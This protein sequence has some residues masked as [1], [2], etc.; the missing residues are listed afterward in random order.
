MR[1]ILA[2]LRS[3][4]V[5][6]GR[7]TAPRIVIGGEDPIATAFGQDA[8]IVFYVSDTQAYIL[9]TDDAGGFGQLFLTY[10]PTL[11]TSLGL[12]TATVD[13]AT[14]VM[15]RADLF[16]SPCD[17]TTLG[18]SS[19]RVWIGDGPGLDTQRI[20]LNADEIR[21]GSAGYPEL[22]MD[23]RTLGFEVAIVNQTPPPATTTAL[24]AYANI[25]GATTAT[26]EKR[27]DNTAVELYMG[28]GMFSTAGGTVGQ[29]GLNISGGF[30]D[31]TIGQVLLSSPSVENC[32]SAVVRVP[33]LSGGGLPAG[34][35]TLTPRWR[36]TAGAGTL[37]LTA[38]SGTLSYYAREIIEP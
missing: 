19:S 17:L 14:E 15:T 24:A 37:T 25:A 20:D 11:G 9:S 26:F 2:G 30:G 22:K 29:Y 18:I 27:Y 6:W 34:T 10:W 5:P 8:A 32:A 33:G 13:L 1:S 21:F 4:V 38:S 7:R 16:S 3:L 28:I 36:R 12:M 31:Q 23:L 35:Y